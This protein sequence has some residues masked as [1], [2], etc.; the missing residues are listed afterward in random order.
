[1]PPQIVMRD[2]LSTGEWQR[3]AQVDP[4]I[5]PRLEEPLLRALARG[6]HLEV[7]ACSRVS[8]RV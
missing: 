5:L 8:L 4:Q 3:L 6:H 1:M 2:L 7:R